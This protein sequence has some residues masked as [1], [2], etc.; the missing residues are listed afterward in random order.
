MVPQ[1]C[2]DPYVGIFCGKPLVKVD[3]VPYLWLSIISILEKQLV[4]EHF[5]AML[6]KPMDVY[7]LPN[8]GQCV[9]VTTTFYV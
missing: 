1:S 9:I 4:H 6:Q 5:F 8:I 3:G 7:V 2:L